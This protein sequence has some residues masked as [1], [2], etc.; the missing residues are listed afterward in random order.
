MEELKLLLEKEDAVEILQRQTGK[1]INEM[2]LDYSHSI[3]PEIPN[4]DFFKKGN[5]FINKHHRYSYTP[6][7]THSFVEFN[8]VYQGTCRQIVNGEEVLLASGQVILMDKN[9]IQQIDTVGEEDLIVNILLNSA[10]LTND[11]L[12]NLGMR[13]SLISLFFIEASQQNS[14]HN[15]FMVFDLNDLPI[16][17]KI[18]EILIEKYL[19]AK[20]PNLGTL[21][22]LLASFLME[23]TEA[24]NVYTNKLFPAKKNQL[25]QILNYLNEH[26][27]DTSLTDLSKKFGYNKNYLSNLIKEKTGS[28]F[29][30]LL[31]TKRLAVAQK[32]LSEG[33]LTISEIS[34]KLGYKSI[35]SLFKLFKNKMGIT[36]KEFQ[37]HHFKKNTIEVKS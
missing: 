16:A 33:D 11:V 28:S 24:E 17:K 34:E 12:D 22:F 29:Q 25:Y 20:N 13:D 36:P 3:V 31:D 21:N 26:Y 35:P 8:Y 6:A 5:I 4:E 1:N 9:I 14:T 32:L 7:H 37:H 2:N 27:T 18:L 15:S 10:T 19:I 23:L 30:E